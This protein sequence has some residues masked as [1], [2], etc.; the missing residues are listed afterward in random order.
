MVL[1][2]DQCLALAI[3]HRC[4]LADD[5][6]GAFVECLQSERGP[7]KLEQC[8][9]DSQIIA[10]ALRGNSRVTKLRPVLGETNDADL[11]S[12]FFAA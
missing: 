6:A 10:N 7:A 12:T 2:T 4:S 9:I 11:S 8:K 1:S 5:A 3:M